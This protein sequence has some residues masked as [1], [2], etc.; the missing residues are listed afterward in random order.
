M[1][2]PAPSTETLMSDLSENT[3]ILCPTVLTK[4]PKGRVQPWKNIVPESYWAKPH[5]S[6]K[7]GNEETQSYIRLFQEIDSISR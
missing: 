3:R 5:T 2:S 4:D 7:F 1:A 6:E